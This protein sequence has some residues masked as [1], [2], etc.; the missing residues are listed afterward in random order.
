MRNALEIV[1]DVRFHR[2]LA[3]IGFF[4]PVGYALWQAL[5][6]PRIEFLPPSFRGE[7]ALH[8]TQEILNFQGGRVSK[9]VEFVRLFRMESLPSRLVLRLRAFTGCRVS[10]NGVVLSPLREETNWKRPREYE[11][12][13]LLRLGENEL[14]VRVWNAG[15]IPALLVESP[16]FLRTRPGWKAA[17]EPT[18]DDWKEVISPTFRA[19]QPGPLQQWSGWRWAREIVRGWLGGTMVLMAFAVGRALRRRLQT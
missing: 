10:L 12:T 16:P 6:N 15:A 18:F 14:R 8:P 1:R 7:W 4:A 13:P 5:W 3:I 2:M 11:A 9:D 19:A 17:L